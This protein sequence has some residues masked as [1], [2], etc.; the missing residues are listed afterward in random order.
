M[1][2][3]SFLNYSFN[4]SKSMGPRKWYSVNR[5]YRDVP[6]RLALTLS[7]KTRSDKLRKSTQ[8]NHEPNEDREDY[9]FNFV[10]HNL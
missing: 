5:W 10:S 1:I 3:K 6:L 2:R 7:P 4:I 8:S 9:H